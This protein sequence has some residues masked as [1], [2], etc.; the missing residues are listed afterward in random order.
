MAGQKRKPL[1]VGLTGGIGSGKTT[2]S[3][4]FAELGAQVVDADVISRALMQ[5]G[6]DTFDAVVAHFGTRVLKQDGSLD[7][8][9]LRRIVFADPGA[10]VWLES[11]LH[12]RIRETILQQIAASGRPWV[13]LSVPLLLESDAYGFVDKVLVVD[14]P[15]ALQL[16]RT[17]QRD[18]SSEAEV[19]AIIAAQM[20]RQ[21]RLARADLVIHN[22]GD[23]ESLR[24]QVA[25]LF[26]RFEELARE[27]H[28][29]G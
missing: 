11:C 16:S 6:N 1:V 10:R 7:R 5:P 28:Q 2:V 20:P 26:Q 27:Q 22:E 15:E 4:L 21:Q 3:D 18:G 9:H 25:H 29:A 12:P 24:A 14:L 13:L 8:A 23:L 17:L 19:R